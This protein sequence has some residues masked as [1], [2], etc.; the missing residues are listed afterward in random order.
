MGRPEVMTDL[1]ISKLEEAY[2]NDATDVEACFVAGVSLG[3]LYNYQR[4]NPDFIE[5]KQA[6]KDSVKYRAKKN[7]VEAITNEEKPDKETSK[8]FLERRAKE[9]FS[10]RNE[11]T[12]AEGKDLQINVISFDA[13]VNKKDAI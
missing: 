13:N 1:A 10:Q 11:H 9:D 7:L 6:L 2:L 4:E 8:W 3:S 5:R 12:G